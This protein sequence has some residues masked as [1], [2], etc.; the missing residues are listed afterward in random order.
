M[1]QPKRQQRKRIGIWNN[2]S[3]TAEDKRARNRQS[4]RLFR[5]RRAL[6][7]QELEARIEY[8]SMGEA[9]RNAALVS[10][11]SALKAA[12]IRARQQCLHMEMLL[13][14][15]NT[16]LST[17][18]G[19]SAEQEDS[20]GPEHANEASTCSNSG[21]SS[22]LAPSQA[23]EESVKRPVEHPSDSG[24]S[25]TSDSNGRAL[26]LRPNHND[27]FNIC[28]FMDYDL[29]MPSLPES[30]S[31]HSQS[32]SPPS[33]NTPRPIPALAW[34][35]DNGPTLL[36]STYLSSG[37]SL[38]NDEYHVTATHTILP[39]SSPHTATSFSPSLRQ[40]LSPPQS[41]E[42]ISGCV[43]AME[44]SLISY[45][46]TFVPQADETFVSKACLILMVYF[47]RHI[48]PGPTM[49][50]FGSHL[51]GLAERSL[52]WRVSK[53][54]GSFKRLPRYLIPT[55]LQSRTPH[56]TIISWVTMGGLRD[57]IIQ[58]CSSGPQFDDMWLD[59]MSHAVIEVEDI[60]T[61]LTG[62]GSGRGF[63]GTWNLFDAMS[64]PKCSDPAQVHGAEGEE[65][66]PEL[67]QLDSSGLLRVYRMPYPGGSS[68]SDPDV[69][70]A[71]PKPNG[72][73]EPVELERLLSEPELARKLYYHLEL[74][75]AHKYWSTD[76]AFYDKYP[77]LKW[78]GYEQF[79]AK[80]R[81]FRLPPRS[82]SIPSRQSL[83]QILIQY[84]LALIT[85][86]PSKMI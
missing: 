6:R 16:T 11:N 21:Q 64:D 43:E 41:C 20:K 33:I 63:L 52:A 58:E 75:N 74:Y 40:W 9:E 70:S 4:Q 69:S 48:W 65:I 7:T 49:L 42:S 67:S 27:P 19:I 25:E 82:K 29:E 36:D 85:M 39:Q 60:S 15:L 73:W 84:Q 50:W 45:L 44:R 38:S 32:K 76:P 46:E 17:A 51:Y 22:S 35:Q 66:F 80:G 56:H 86:N 68:N 57:R 34:E 61:I 55:P 2:G 53:S 77:N 37:L 5:E 81:S 62:V 47:A 83:D 71:K 8:L 13:G 30:F 54:K 28:N 23:I 18:L 59:L 10:T 12:L 72:P 3:D 24:P 1:S 26:T 31:V 14:N 78:E 79:N